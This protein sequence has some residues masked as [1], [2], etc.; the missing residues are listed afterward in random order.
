MNTGYGQDNF[1]RLVD[2]RDGWR[3]RRKERER[4]RER[5]RVLRESIQ[6]IRLDDNNDIYIYIYIYTRIIK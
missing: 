1:E 2:D 4:E 6:L 3:E 5:E